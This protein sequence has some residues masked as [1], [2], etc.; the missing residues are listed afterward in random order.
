MS[1]TRLH[2]RYAVRVCVLNHSTSPA[3]IDHVLGWLE[4]ARRSRLRDA[5]VATLPESTTADLRSGWP[6]A[7]GAARRAAPRCR[8]WRGSRSWLSWVGSVARRRHG[9]GGRDRRPAVGRWT[10]TSTCSS[11]GEADVIGKD[12]QLSTHGAGRL[13]RRAGRDRLGSQLRLPAAGHGD[14]RA[15][16]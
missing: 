14:G 8:C 1:S 15:P 10:A 13:L 16:T 3:D 4:T 9:R 6:G 5:A 11:T 12:G 2:G 7:V